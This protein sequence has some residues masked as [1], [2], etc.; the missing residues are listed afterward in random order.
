M[1]TCAKCNKPYP[2]ELF[3]GVRGDLAKRCAYCRK[4]ESESQRRYREANRE[5]L[6][7]RQRRYREANPEKVAEIKRRYYEA[8]PE[9]N[10]ARCRRWYQ[11]KCKH[12]AN[13]DMEALFPGMLM[14]KITQTQ[15]EKA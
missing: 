10:A 8:N 1:K 9:K 7:E 6:A 13:A 3:I 12:Q 11:E 15:M 5:K 14:S 2:D 4:R